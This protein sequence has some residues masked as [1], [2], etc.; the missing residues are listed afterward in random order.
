MVSSLGV[1]LAPGVSPVGSSFFSSFTKSQNCSRRSGK[2][3]SVEVCLSLFFWPRNSREPICGGNQPTLPLPYFQ[4][5]SLLAALS[6]MKPQRPPNLGMECCWFASL[7]PSL[8][9]SIGGDDDAL[10]VHKWVSHS[11][12]ILFSPVSTSNRANTLGQQFVS[13]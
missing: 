5:S 4:L 11:R 3:L 7:G 13:P 9:D 1:R 12:L 2:P 10:N 6:T 8:L